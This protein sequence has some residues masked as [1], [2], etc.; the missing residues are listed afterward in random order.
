MSRRETGC[1]LR[2]SAVLW[3]RAQ[4]PMQCA[5]QAARHSMASLLTVSKPGG[6]GPSGANALLCFAAGTEPLEANRVRWLQPHDAIQGCVA[7]R[8]RACAVLHLRR[9]TAC[10]TPSASTRRT[11]RAACSAWI[12]ACS[13][14]LRSFRRSFSVFCAAPR[15]R[16]PQLVTVPTASSHALQSRAYSKQCKAADFVAHNMHAVRAHV[17][18]RQP[19]TPCDTTFRVGV[20]LV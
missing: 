2:S 3:R 20:G 18:K 1:S 11:R 13:A 16:R 15:A 19:A 14:R 9:P 17:H 4:A 12:A 7:P 10:A 6:S 8:G 5:V